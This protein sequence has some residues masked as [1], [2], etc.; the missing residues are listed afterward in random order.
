MKLRP[1]TEADCRLLWRWRNEPEVRASAFQSERITWK[2]HVAWF[3]A[4]SRDPNCFIYIIENK[5]KRP[6]GQI[7]FDVDGGC[8]AETNISIIKKLRGRGYGVA[9]LCLACADLVRRVS[10]NQIVA[11]IKPKNLAS[12]R[13]FQ[14]SG[15]VHR[16]TEVKKGC[17]AL[18]L[19]MDRSDFTRL[20]LGV[21]G[22]KE[23]GRIV[24]LRQ[25]E[26]SGKIAG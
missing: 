23:T 2:R 26:F 1:A 19:I 6:I 15:F 4:K 16:T 22:V 24:G 10:V 18:C 3:R 9:A 25:T 7:R 5:F 8:R 13:M 21:K 12:I 20:K 14:R 11:H 17:E